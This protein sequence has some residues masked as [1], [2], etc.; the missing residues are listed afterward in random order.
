MRIEYIYKGKSTI[1]DS[2]YQVSFYSLFIVENLFPMYSSMSVDCVIKTAGLF[3]P[4]RI[5]GA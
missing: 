1:I 3:S 4:L 2:C 5:K